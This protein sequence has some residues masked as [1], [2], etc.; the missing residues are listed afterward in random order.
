MHAS[1]LNP[2]TELTIHGAHLPHWQQDET[3]CF[4]TWRLADSLP[5]SLVRS[6]EQ[7]RSI[8]L[9]KNPPPLS[10][11]QQ[12][13]YR[14]EFSERIDQWLDQGMGSRI[15]ARPE[16]A[17]RV[18]ETLRHDEG[19]QYA[20]HAFVIMPTHVHVLFSRMPDY[21]ID[22]IVQAWKSVSARRLGRE[23]GVRTP[24]WQAG[25]WDRL[26]RNP[27]HFQGCVRYI[28]DNPVNAGLRDGEW[29]AWTDEGVRP[30]TTDEGVRLPRRTRAS[31][32]R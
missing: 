5:M 6:W 1:F 14:R 26:I 7:E 9:K 25:Y 3:T 16:C 4:V 23:C 19:V 28:R 21:R 12:Q 29:V 22:K 11:S 30:P 24:V 32:L 13:T 18:A 20:L 31:V 8:W 27:K 17:A 10:L 2:H 15:L